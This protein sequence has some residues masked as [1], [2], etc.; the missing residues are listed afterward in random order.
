MVRKMILP[1]SKRRHSTKALF[2]V[3]D[4]PPNAAGVVRKAA[5]QLK[6]EGVEIYAIAVGKNAGK[7]SLRRLAS[8]VE[9]VFPVKS[10]KDLKNL[11]RKMA[12]LSTKSR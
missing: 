2:L 9:N 10:F 4:G 8:K 1:S 7:T 5:D 6:K 11:N 12:L 3:T